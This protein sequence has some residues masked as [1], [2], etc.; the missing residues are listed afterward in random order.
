MGDLRADLVELA[1]HAAEQGAAR[2][3]LAGEPPGQHLDLAAGH[4]E[5]LGERLG[6]LRAGLLERGPALL[7]HRQHR[8]ALRLEPGAR[9]VDR[10]GGARHRA[11][12]RRVHLRRGLV[13]PLGGGAGA[14][15]DPRDMG[16]EPLRRA[17]GHL[18][19]LAAARGQRRELAVERA[20][21]LVR[22]EARPA[23]SPRRRRAPA[24]RPWA[25]RSSARR[26]RP[27]PPRRPWSSA[28]AL[29]SS[30]AVSRASVL[31]D[32]ADPVGGLVAEAH[33]PRRFLAQR[34]A[35]LGESAPR[36]RRA[37]SRAPRS[38]A[39]IAV[40]AS[41][42]RARLAPRAAPEHQ[43]EQADQDQ[44][45]AERRR[46]ADPGRQARPRPGQAQRIAG[47]ADPAQSEQ[48]QQAGEDPA[49]PSAAARARPRYPRCGSR[50]RRPAP[51][52]ASR[53]A[54]R[55]R[56]SCGCA[57]RALCPHAHGRRFVPLWAGYET[58]R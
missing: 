32:P 28:C 13:H 29:R 14:A 21:L 22:G 17:A 24:P 1:R 41:V 39:R 46:P 55:S 48:D 5:P 58:A 23:S 3:V 26:Y 37:R 11:V 45:R 47:R 20:G 52:T 42:K 27:A 19:G 31:G 53:R 44:R 16:A 33:Q 40:T 12:D 35:I 4:V 56:R 6:R 57:S 8:L 49:R 50:R 10:F 30:S 43:P 18:V 34:R 54:T 15:F 9:L 25:D 38:R 51:P 36:P 7:D 2:R